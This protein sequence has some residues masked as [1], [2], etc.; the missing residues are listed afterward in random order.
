[1]NRLVRQ[2]EK[3]FNQLEKKRWDK[4]YVAIDVHETILEP[5]WSDVLS[6]KFY[7]DS[8]D[9]L[10]LLSDRKDICLILW[11]SSNKENAQAYSD[12][13]KTEGVNMDY[14]NSNPEVTEK[15]YAD[16]DSKFYVNLILDDKS[17]F[18]PDEDWK[19]LKGYLKLKNLLEEGV[20]MKEVFVTFM[21]TIK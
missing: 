6:H 12:L 20:I 9:T 14:I 3:S 15:H 10:K 8:L 2:L 11:T 17:G 5:T 7:P 21:E 18:L 4:I 1:M 16:Y 13:L 19:A